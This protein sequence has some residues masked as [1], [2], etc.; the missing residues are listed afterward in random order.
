MNSKGK[1]NASN[2]NNNKQKSQEEAEQEYE[3]KTRTT[4]SWDKNKVLSKLPTFDQSS[5]KILNSAPTPSSQLSQ[6]REKILQKNKSKEQNDEVNYTKL[7]KKTKKEKKA[8]TPLLEDI[9]LETVGQ[10]PN[11]LYQTMKNKDITAAELVLYTKKQKEYIANIA[12][13]I[14]EDPE[15]NYKKLHDLH[16]LCEF[17]PATYKLKNKKKLSY[18]K[19]SGNNKQNEDDEEEE[20][21]EANKVLPAFVKTHTKVRQLAILSMAALFSDILPGYRVKE[22]ASDMSNKHQQLKKEVLKV[23]QFETSLVSAYQRYLVLLERFIKENTPSLYTSSLKAYCQVLVSKPHFN[24]R[25]SIL[26]VIVSVLGSGD[27]K[28]C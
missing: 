8:K 13:T 7:N 5:G 12:S 23:R 24:F 27:S 2:N 4:E 20:E 6:V 10:L 3:K 25:S 26:Q 21:S 16:V 15:S 14:M 28:V 17:N 19:G 1:K 9:E 11:F 22:D 18:R